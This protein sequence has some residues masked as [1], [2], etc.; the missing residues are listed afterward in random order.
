MRSIRVDRR[1]EELVTRERRLTRRSAGLKLLATVLLAVGLL[2]A[3][4]TGLASSAVV[5]LL[6]ASSPILAA[7]GVAALAVATDDGI[8][9]V[10]L[11]R[12]ALG[13]RPEPE[14]LDHARRLRKA[15]VIAAVVAV[16]LALVGAIGS[17]VAFR[18]TD[19]AAVHALVTAPLPLSVVVGAM[20]F[21]L[22]R[23]GVAA[24]ALRH[25]GRG[26]GALRPA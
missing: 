19:S 18:A 8:R 12:V 16:T 11:V 3:V 9:R 23:L 21:R 17:I 7:V 13:D 10:R 4:V 1:R 6:V 5:P 26:R 15:A 25:D 22:H 2:A 24:G 20:A 14:H